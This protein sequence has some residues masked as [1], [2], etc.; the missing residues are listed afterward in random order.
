MYSGYPIFKLI[1]LT[2]VLLMLN[3]C[4]FVGTQSSEKEEV[5]KVETSSSSS[6]IFGKGTGSVP[7]KQKLSTPTPLKILKNNLASQ[8]DIQIQVPDPLPIAWANSNQQVLIRW[9]GQN[10]QANPGMDQPEDN[11]LPNNANGISFTL[12]RRLGQSKNYELLQESITR[13]ESLDQAQAF[14]GPWWTE[15]AE[16]IHTYS[17][18]SGNGNLENESDAVA[19]IRAKTV[20]EL[21]VFDAY[22]VFDENP[23]AATLWANK[24]HEI[25]RLLGIGFLDENLMP[26]STVQYR[27]FFNGSEDIQPVLIGE[28]PVLK[29]GKLL[30][31]FDIKLSASSDPQEVMLQDV[32]VNDN[33]DDSDWINKQA[34]RRW[35]DKRI[36]L[37]WAIE[38]QD[39]SPMNPFNISGYNVYRV[40]VDK[41]LN[42]IGPVTKINTETVVSSGGKLNSGF[43]QPGAGALGIYNLQGPSDFLFI[44]EDYDSEVPNQIYCYAATWIDLLGNESIPSKFDHNSC[45]TFRDNEPPSVPIGLTANLVKEIEAIVLTW[46]QVEGAGSYSVYRT[47]TEPGTP[48]ST[49]PDDWLK[50]NEGLQVNILADPDSNKKLVSFTD[51]SGL[52]LPSNDLQEIDYWYRVRSWKNNSNG[53]ALSQPVFVFMRDSVPPGAPVLQVREPR[54]YVEGQVVQDDG[55]CLRVSID[56]DTDFIQI[57]RRLQDGSYQLVATIKIDQNN[58]E[59]WCDQLGAM[60]G[61]VG[62]SYIVQAHDSDGNYSYSE[63]I[64]IVA[65]DGQFFDAPVIT[66]I[67][68]LTQSGQTKNFISWKADLYPD[69]DQVKLYRF[70]TENEAKIAISNPGQMPSPISSLNVADISTPGNGIAEGKFIDTGLNVHLSDFYYVVSSKR[71]SYTPTHEAFSNPSQ[72]VMA[73]SIDKPRSIRNIAQALWCAPHYHSPGDGVRIVWH[74]EE[75]DSGKCPETPHDE[76]GAHLVFRSRK[77]DSGYVQIAPVIGGVPGQQNPE[78]YYASPSVPQNVNVGI[79]YHD[80]DADYGTYWYVVVTVDPLSGEPV[81]VTPPRSITLEN[82][83]TLTPVEF[84]AFRCRKTDM[85]ETA[86]NQL[87]FGYGGQYEGT[88][89]ICRLS[90]Y[91]QQGEDSALLTGVG[92]A[93]FTN[94]DRSIKYP[95]A[96]S[97]ENL[98]VKSSGVVIS[99]SATVD[100]GNIGIHGQD[101]LNYSISNIVF[102]H[103]DGVSADVEVQL[104][105]DLQ[106]IQ[107][108]VKRKL[109]SFEDLS[110]TSN[111]NFTAFKELGIGPIPEAYQSNFIVNLPPLPWYLVLD[112]LPIAFI[113]DRIVITQSY[114]KTG[115]ATYARYYERHN[116]RGISGPLDRM[117][118]NEKVN[119]ND[120]ILQ[121]AVFNA[122]QFISTVSGVNTLL[123]S[124]SGVSGILSI[125]YKSAIQSSVATINIEDSRISG[126]NL[127]GNGQFLIEYKPI[128]SLE[129]YR[130]VVASFNSLE[131]S[132][133]SSVYGQVSQLNE[134]SWL[135][136]GF[137]VGQ[138]FEN[139][140]EVVVAPIASLG[141][142]AKPIR[143]DN[144][145]DNSK[146]LWDPVYSDNSKWLMPGLNLHG[147]GPVRWDCLGTEFI[148]DIDIYVRRGGVSHVLGSSGQQNIAGILGGDPGPGYT[149]TIEKADFGFLDSKIVVSS[150][151]LQLDIPFPA[152]FSVGGTVTKWSEAGACP[153]ELDVSG[154]Q[155]VL[156]DHWNLPILP[157]LVNFEE[158]S[159][160]GTFATRLFIN[161]GVDL[162]HALSNTGQDIDWIPAQTRWEPTGENG[163]FKFNTLPILKFDG[164]NYLLPTLDG[165]HLSN[166]GSSFNDYINPASN[167]LE[168]PCEGQ[169][170]P[171]W[172]K[173]EG[174]TSVPFFGPLVNTDDSDDEVIALLV[175]TD[176]EDTVNECPDCPLYIGSDGISAQAY[177]IS[178]LGLGLNYPLVIAKKH[179]S[180]G[181][182][183]TSIK[184]HQVLPVLEVVQF[185]SSL[186]IDSSVENNSIDTIVSIFLG[187]N[188]VPAS[189]RAIADALGE[190][191]FS[192]LEPS[193][194]FSNQKFSPIYKRLYL[195]S[196]QLHPGFENCKSITADIWSDINTYHDV[197][198]TIMSSECL[199][200]SD[201]MEQRLNSIIYSNN[202]LI[203][204]DYY[205]RRLLQLG[206]GA[207]YILSS[208]ED[209][210]LLHEGLNGYGDLG[211]EILQDISEYFDIENLQ[212]NAFAI[213]E[214]LT[215][216]LQQFCPNGVGVPGLGGGIGGD[217]KI[218]FRHPR[219]IVAF[220]ANQNTPGNPSPGVTFDRLDL[221]VALSVEERSPNEG[222]EP[223]I[224]LKGDPFTIGITKSGDFT[225]SALGLT[226]KLLKYEIDNT[227]VTLTISSHTGN[228]GIQGGITIPSELD[229]DMFK[230]EVLTGVFGIGDNLLYLGVSGDG[231]IDLSGTESKVGG[232]LLLGEINSSSV[233]VL[234]N[235]G[236]SALTSSF[237]VND[238]QSISGIYVRVMGTVPLVNNGCALTIQAG[239]EVEIWYFVPEVYGGSLR[240]FVTGKAL[241]IAS[242]RGD[243]SLQLSKQGDI[244]EFD[245]QGWLCGGTG[246]DCDPGDWGPSWE[247]RW[248]NDDWCW[249]FGAAADLN[250]SSDHGNWTYNLDADYE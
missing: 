48:Y 164:L 180:E 235:H 22:A 9:F 56:G 219:G 221:S 104:G 125:P 17:L 215:E 186:V 197:P 172:L 55:P 241:C 30:E 12:E 136:D 132:L 248:W 171:G 145:K 105:N 79:E 246:L 13:I 190:T 228:I 15:L 247:G 128:H 213:P 24:Y 109:I 129:E 54:K 229:L 184:H 23:L 153:K 67:L 224:F 78:G 234:N 102:D 216:M 31:A 245:G 116:A 179:T 103:Q 147:S 159:V 37:N 121:S 106:I 84:S 160:E 200:Y 198:N 82:L 64:Q 126:G 174:K 91:Q 38:L 14:I 25:S 199:G 182:I 243:V 177:W 173:Y 133:A 154:N 26:G 42:P 53:S 71:V 165:I 4:G 107:D 69:F 170:C 16:Y 120:S 90:N 217:Y 150:A 74:S 80:M 70:N 237:D 11:L 33:A 98:I 149:T 231:V 41:Q 135:E 47:A 97:F 144:P 163:A 240:G 8:E 169:S 75:T 117:P 176:H 113:T 43:H 119:S 110:I 157:S 93:L 95:V 143:L 238:N 87:I 210:L 138:G 111:L 39:K 207:G 188:S 214:E 175:F 81:S 161:G 130:P 66:S 134:L 151:G 233:P 112:N 211:Y 72:A 65:G 139:G 167:V 250:W 146:S 141:I 32:N 208:C 99:G 148:A 40:P 137:T 3:A 85:P 96:V 35:V 127:S 73:D 21:T 242:A 62:A 49:D 59:D 115:E 36:Y 2:I 244:F 155:E 58:W 92:Q 205:L 100:N 209:L 88:V 68:T 131:I 108:G 44:D 20:D 195:G 34:H 142:P 51:T 168:P 122:S 249:Q 158:V 124:N 46:E 18:A 60:T 6:D 227:D 27:M 101:S 63:E 162:P 52:I 29:V 239:A 86:P 212:Q 222:H 7:F 166:P 57:Y 61:H 10:G 50:V 152:N 178:D 77:A 223:E 187:V 206:G 89:S 185:D 201:E 28:T 230:A 225:V 156:A 196:E 45:E 226:A 1:G 204:K 76:T 194:W 191:V 118:K 123:T 181:L 114:L 83:Q 192:N 232:S 140:W 183:L 193:R 202:N 19:S 189:T 203:P 94:D 220:V 236:F 5:T 218:K